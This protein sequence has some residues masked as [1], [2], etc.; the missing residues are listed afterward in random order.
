MIKM[1]H[2]KKLDISL[3]SDYTFKYE[4]GHNTE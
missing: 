2:K 3:I 4:T 1:K